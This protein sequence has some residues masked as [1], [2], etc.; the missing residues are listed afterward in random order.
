MIVPIILLR[1]C[2]VVAAPNVPHDIAAEREEEE[3]LPGATLLFRALE[4]SRAR[5]FVLS[6]FFNNYV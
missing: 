6:L 5:F 4:L 1:P 2:Q 3:R